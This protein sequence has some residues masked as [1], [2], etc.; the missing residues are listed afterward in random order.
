MSEHPHHEMHVNSLQAHQEERSTG[1]LSKRCAAIMAML[2][3][4]TMQH[5]GRSD[6]AIMTMMG[7][8]DPNS[9]RPR[10]S[11]MLKAGVLQ[12]CGST[13]DPVTGKWVRLVRIK[14]KAEN[15]S[16]F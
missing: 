1:R 10:L 12:E 6:R 9:V 13:R 2:E 16:L 8:N 7:F 11:E 15:L 5:L 4:D 3:N 14:R